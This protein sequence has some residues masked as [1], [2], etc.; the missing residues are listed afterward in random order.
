M[1][2]I[3]NS[4]SLP[5]THLHLYFRTNGKPSP[6]WHPQSVYTMIFLFGR[7]LISYPQDLVA[8][9]AKI[10]AELREESHTL[11]DIILTEVNL[12]LPRVPSSNTTTSA[13]FAIL[14]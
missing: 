5:P 3:S 8:R 6:W 1:P 7:P 13:N 2:S 4:K 9:D 12:A 14:N 11:A 10:S